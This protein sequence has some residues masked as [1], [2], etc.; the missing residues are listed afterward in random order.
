MTRFQRA[1]NDP[2]TK[3]QIKELA[4]S[5]GASIKQVTRVMSD[6][7]AHDEVWLND[8]YQVNVRRGIK[9]DGWPE[10][11]WLSIKRRDKRSIHD[12]RE[13]QEVKNQLVGKEHEAIELYPAES[14]KVDGSNQYH[15]WVLAE[16]G[17]RVPLGVGER[18]V[19]DGSGELERDG[20]RQRPL[21]KGGGK[22]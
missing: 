9:A 17:L 12:W 21:K 2:P 14:R 6:I 18:H 16:R 15:L 13:L 19:R 22:G 8:T 7:H 1:V 20:T 4:K 10:L 11:I 5:S 3:R